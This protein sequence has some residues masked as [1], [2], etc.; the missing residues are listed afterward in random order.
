M[1][2]NETIRLKN[3]SIGCN[4]KGRGKKYIAQEINASLYEG[5]LTC[6]L[7]ANGAGK[8]TLL[9]TLSA[10]LPPLEGEVLLKGKRIEE[11]SAN[12]RARLVGVVLTEKPELHHMMVGEL[13]GMGRSPYTNFWGSLST[14]DCEAVNK[15]L[16]IVGMSD[17]ATRLVDTLS[18]GERQKVMI[19]KALAQETPVI[20]LDEPT[21]F[22][23]YPSKVDTML[24]LRQLA[25]E[26]GKTIFLSTH[27]VELALQ[28]ADTLWLMK[29]NRVKGEGGGERIS[30]PT[31]EK[32]PSTIKPLTIG[33][34]KE[35]AEN[36]ALGQFF[37]GKDFTFDQ[38]EMRFR[39]VASD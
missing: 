24:L 31:Q 29:R 12:E 9:R 20:Y 11:Y 36:G 37:T 3:L 34:P 33:S 15:A 5:Q 35:L 6:L 14:T 38:Q 18:D 30:L 2:M 21:A 19:A 28:T 8:S 23:D 17:F 22:L 26:T 7:G 25:H 39:I 32:T 1:A 27:D 13:V 4:E 16:E 10:F